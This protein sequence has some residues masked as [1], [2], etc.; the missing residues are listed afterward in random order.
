[1][2]FMRL[3]EDCKQICYLTTSQQYQVDDPDL[4]GLDKFWYIY[5]H[6]V[7]SKV[8]KKSK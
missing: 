1:M 4:V 3:N 7:D 5:F 8:V 2:L 6:C